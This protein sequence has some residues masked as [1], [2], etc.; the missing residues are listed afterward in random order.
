MVNLILKDLRIMKKTMFYMFI[1]V[2]MVVC[3]NVYRSVSLSQYSLV[4]YL[5]IVFFMSYFSFT[6]MASRQNRGEAIIMNSLPV[7][8]KDLVS[9]KY[10]MVI[11]Y[12]LIFT[13]ALMTETVFL[14]LIAVEGGNIVT[15]EVLMISLMLCF[16]YFSIYIPLSI[17]NFQ[18]ANKVNIIMYILIILTPQ[19]LK[20]L[21]DTQMGKR[22]IVFISGINN[23]NIIMIAI[24]VI[25]ILMYV[26]SFFTSVKIYKNKE[27]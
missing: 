25:S 10:V 23:K 13:F 24:F 18:N 9:L 2:S 21:A 26:I 11:I 15:L 8:G 6:Y 3:Y 22:F 14:K 17:K 20:K 1:P 16:I 12:N 7:R 4:A 19:I 5:F 27:F